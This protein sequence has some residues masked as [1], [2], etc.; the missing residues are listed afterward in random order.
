M[1]GS[2][3]TKFQYLVWQDVYRVE[4]PFKL[5]LDLPAHVTDQRRTNLIFAESS[6]EPVVD[7][8]GQEDSYS[9]DVNG[10]QFAVH[11]TSVPDLRDA[12][13]VER[14]YFD[15]VK[16]IIRHNVADADRVEIF[17]WRVSAV[18]SYVDDFSYGRAAS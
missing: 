12:N 14:C 18:N 2:T 15:E 16:D 13:D 7:V 3:R 6:P 4:K 8:R 9:L 1:N 5:F 11:H 17:D 10:F